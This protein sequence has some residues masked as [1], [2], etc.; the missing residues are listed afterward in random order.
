MKFKSVQFNLKLLSS[1]FCCDTVYC[2]VQHAAL[3]FQPVGEILY[4]VD[5]QHF[6]F[7]LFIMR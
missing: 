4:C 6:S 2:D 5:K 1:I 3:T 7:V